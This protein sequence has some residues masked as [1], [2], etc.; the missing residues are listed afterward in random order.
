MPGRLVAA[1]LLVLAGC[2][3]A[4]PGGQPD[5]T[6]PTTPSTT[7]ASTT[8]TVLASCPNAD[9]IPA[10]ATEHFAVA[11][12]LDGDGRDD[13]LTSYLHPQEGWRLRV[14]LARGGSSEVAMEGDPLAGHR[15]LGGAD[16]DG[17][18]RSEA[19]AL[20]GQG[21]YTLLIGLWTLPGCELVPVT[22]G[23][24]PAVFPVGASVANVVG[25]SCTTGEGLTA[26]ALEST[27]GVAYTGLATDYR[28]EDAALVEDGQA[29]VAVTADRT[30]ALSGLRCE[31]M[32]LG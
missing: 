13:V 25:L 9:P 7:L 15:V 30:D 18:G 31:E 23:P 32:S 8:S 24:V 17:D 19:F 14:D 5:T 20:V 29:R 27:D 28:L 22:L 2:A 1:F 3:R 11:D 21:A 4:A 6:P 26:T 12:D 16:L 10:A